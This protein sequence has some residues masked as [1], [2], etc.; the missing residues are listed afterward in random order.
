MVT[1]YDEQDQQVNTFVNLKLSVHN[2]GKNT[3]Y[4]FLNFFIIT[5][6]HGRKQFLFIIFLVITL[7]LTSVKH[8]GQ[9]C[10]YHGQESILDL[11]I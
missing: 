6:K 8:K 4:Q 7:V 5:K 9:F 3:M 11:L 10:Y 1:K 2:D